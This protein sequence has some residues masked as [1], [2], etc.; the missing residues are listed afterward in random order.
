M[1]VLVGVQAKQ[2]CQRPKVQC[3][4]RVVCVRRLFFPTQQMEVGVGDATGCGSS[5]PWF[6]PTC[7]SASACFL[8][9]LLAHGWPP[10]L[11]S[12]CQVIHRCR[13]KRKWRASVFLIR[14]I[15][16]S[17]PFYPRAQPQSNLVSWR[18]GNS[19]HSWVPKHIAKIY[20]WVE[21]GGARGG[22]TTKRTK[23]RRTEEQLDVSNHLDK[24]SP[25]FGYFNYFSF[26]TN[27]NNT[28]N[29]LIHLAPPS[30]QPHYSKHFTCVLT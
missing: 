22:S 11:Q 30:C 2:L 6:L 17:H 13:G 23:G 29:T 16:H 25:I 26:F 3:L 19:V 18:L 15:T 21:V 10:A 8:T 1:A 5:G 9:H 7:C 12:G 27:I 20:V 24:L 14:N 4:Q 28:V